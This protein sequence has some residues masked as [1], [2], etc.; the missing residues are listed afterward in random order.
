M[1]KKKKY[2]ISFIWEWDTLPSY[3]KFKLSFSGHPYY[4]MGQDSFFQELLL[5]TSCCFVFSGELH[6][7]IS[8]LKMKC[9]DQESGA[10][11]VTPG[12]GIEEEEIIQVRYGI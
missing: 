3:I 2:K 11:V 7:A 9:C 5:G 8:D 4:P 12:D 10:P 6:P 1:P